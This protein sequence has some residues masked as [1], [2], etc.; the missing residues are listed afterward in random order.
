MQTKMKFNIL[1]F[2]F[3]IYFNEGNELVVPLAVAEVNLK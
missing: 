1:T 3:V 2:Y